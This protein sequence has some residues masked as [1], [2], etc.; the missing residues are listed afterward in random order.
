V[1]ILSC[2]VS[3]FIVYFFTTSELSARWVIYKL[4]NMKIKETP[5]AL[6]PAQTFKLWN[7]T[8][9]AIWV[10]YRDVNF[11]ISYVK[12]N[13]S[14]K[15]GNCE[16]F[17]HSFHQ[18]VHKNNLNSHRSSASWYCTQGSFLIF[19]RERIQLQSNPAKAANTLFSFIS[20]VD[21]PGLLD[22]MWDLEYKLHPIWL[23]I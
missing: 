6:S 8:C 14:L 16:I 17:A 3:T 22:F 19:I 10:M 12:I 13:I 2:A 21:F 23:E 5:L 15:Q 4:M 1:L 18:K 9:I 11:V 20:C 7:Y